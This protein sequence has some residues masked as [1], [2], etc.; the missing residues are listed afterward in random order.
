MESLVGLREY[1]Q[2]LLHRFADSHPVS[3]IQLGLAHRHHE[4]VFEACKSFQV[5]GNLAYCN[6]IQGRPSFILLLTI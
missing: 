3:D 2:V 4:V 5:A 6:G 1:H